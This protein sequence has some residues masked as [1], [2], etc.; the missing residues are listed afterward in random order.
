[1]S[2][3]NLGTLSDSLLSEA[4]AIEVA[5]WTKVRRTIRGAGAPEREP[6][7]YGFP[8][9]KNYECSVTPFATSADAVLPWLEKYGVSHQYT[10]ERG[11][12]FMLY[13]DGFAHGAR[14]QYCVGHYME[15]SPRTTFAR[16]ACL[17]LIRARRAEA[18]KEAK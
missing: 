17:A 1:M 12:I 3:D 14:C 5:G 11:H 8:P 10:P 4:F 18:R 2:N 9:G 16:A 13:S 15:P 6:S 7:P